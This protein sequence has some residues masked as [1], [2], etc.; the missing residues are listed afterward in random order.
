MLYIA[1]VR[2]GFRDKVVLD[3]GFVR[4]NYNIADGLTKGMCQ[5]ALRKADSSGKLSFPPEQWI[6][7]NYI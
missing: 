4:S 3:I 6:I 5:A 7:P 1:A 2:T